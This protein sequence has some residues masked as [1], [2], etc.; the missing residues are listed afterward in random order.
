MLRR[1]SIML[2]AVPIR[3]YRGFLSPLTPPACRFHPSCSAYALEAIETHGPLKGL[4]LA[5]KR[6][7]RCHPITWLGGGSGFDPVPPQPKH[8]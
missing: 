4:F 8:S 3:F 1:L 6:L 5:A 7:C 2:L